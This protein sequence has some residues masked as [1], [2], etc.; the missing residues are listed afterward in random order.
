MT[1]LNVNVG[2]DAGSHTSKI[3][4]DDK[5]IAGLEGF[6]LL[7]LREESEVFFD[8]PVF[9]CVI[10]L[11]DAFTRKQRD[12]IIFDAKKSGFKKIDV[13]TSHEAII[14]AL[15]ENGRV[16]VYDFGASKSDIIIFDGD[17]KIL[18][19]EIFNDI[20][21][22]E[23]DNVFAQ[24]LSERFTLN[25]ID[26]K[27][28][29]GHAGKIKINLS[30]NDFV[31]WR[32]V[33]ITRDDFERLIRFTVKRALHTVERFITC[34]RP[35]KFIMTGGCSEIPLVK[36]IFDGLN[37]ETEFNA[38][39][40]AQG[41]AV[42]A[43]SLSKENRST[44]KSGTA[45]K[46]RELRGELMELEDLLTRKQKD[47]LYFLFKKAEGILTNDPALITLMENLIK[48]VRSESS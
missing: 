11:P 22:N 25:L 35:R 37:I 14:N 29:R 19:N 27:I 8:E 1:D 5:K 24:W 7:K 13:I 17:K 41:A 15:R 42:K 6:D 10:A 21:G 18:D 48:E 34:Y 12:D 46:I 16:L 30:L 4:Y 38:D 44:D 40:I 43:R 20:S 45:S 47:R 32:D 28:L 3:A 23:F 31:I 26:E 39:L 33:Y 2:I 36:K 9:S